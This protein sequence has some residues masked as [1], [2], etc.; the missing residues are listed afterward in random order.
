MLLNLIFTVEHEVMKFEKKEKK[1]TKTCG[2]GRHR[3]NT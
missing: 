2:R 3:G 1:L